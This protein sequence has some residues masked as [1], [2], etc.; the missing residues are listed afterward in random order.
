MAEFGDK[1]DYVTYYRNL[2]FYLRQGMRLK[3]VKR[4]IIFKATPVMRNFIDEM[5]ER[6]KNAKSTSQSKIFK[7]LNN[8]LYVTYL[9]ILSILNSILIIYFFFTG[10]N[11]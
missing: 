3:K 7:L 10:E 4:A 2:A 8:S 1:T 5:S 11:G 6:R 9:Y